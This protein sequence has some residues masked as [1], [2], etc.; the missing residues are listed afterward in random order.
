M[1]TTLNISLRSDIPACP[2]LSCGQGGLLAVELKSDSIAKSRDGSG[3]IIGT[4]A[5]K[6]YPLNTVGPSDWV[7]QVTFN[8]VEFSD[9]VINGDLDPL[10]VADIASGDGAIGLCCLHCGDLMLLD[11]IAAIQTR[12]LNRESFRF[13]AHDEEFVIGVHRLFRNHSAI[14]IHAIEVSCEEH[15]TG[16]P[17][18][19]PQSVAIRLVRTEPQQAGPFNDATGTDVVLDPASTTPLTAKLEFAP[20]LL[21]P[22]GAGV[23]ININSADPAQHLGLEVHIDFRVIDES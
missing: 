14:E 6:P 3:W 16:Y 15:L 5:N 18:V 4:I 12:T 9:E 13:F 17:A 20:P 11:K 10:E 7:Y 23:G 8:E 22:A 2:P 1:N 21:I 19:E